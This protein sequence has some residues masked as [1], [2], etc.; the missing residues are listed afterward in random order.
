MR[1]LPAL[2]LAVSLAACD[3]LVDDDVLVAFGD[4]YAVLQAPAGPS[5]DG[6]RLRVAVEYGG[7]C[8]EHTFTPLSYRE[9]GV[10]RVWL[11]HDANGDA[12][13]ALLRD[14]LDLALPQQAA[15]AGRVLL[16][17]PGGAE[18]RLR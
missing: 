12:C 7:G 15:D 8:A 16:L 9:G 17:T 4:D 3:G 1:V 2:V 14:A 10:A 11:V 6:G 5:I 13:D 18:V